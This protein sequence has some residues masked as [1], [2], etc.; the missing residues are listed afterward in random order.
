MNNEYKIYYLGGF[1]CWSDKQ[2]EDLRLS[3]IGIS[4]FYYFVRLFRLNY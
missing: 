3:E 2:F 4:I 1:N